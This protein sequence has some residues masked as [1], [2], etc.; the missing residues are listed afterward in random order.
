MRASS[1]GEWSAPLELVK[2]TFAVCTLSV[3]QCCFILSQDSVMLFSICV[4][5]CYITCR[6]C[7]P[8]LCKISPFEDYT[9]SML[10][11]ARY[12]ALPHPQQDGRADMLPPQ[13]ERCL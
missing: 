4:S 9:L 1:E 13:W 5:Q 8:L 10:K 12:N 3:T 2:G 6:Q 7:K 11:Y